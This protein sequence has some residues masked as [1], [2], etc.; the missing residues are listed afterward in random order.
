LSES[1]LDTLVEAVHQRHGFDV[2]A[3]DMSS[4]PLTMEA[5]LICTAANRIQARAISDHI[6]KTARSMGYRKHHLEGYDE[7]SWILLDFVDL[8]V[9]IFLPETR[10]YYNL[11]GLWSDLPRNVYDDGE[12]P[13]DDGP[14]DPQD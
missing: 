2:I 13:L 6:E 10:E 8:V 9:H 7:G 3:L 4:V 5:F 11:E 12:V 1:I 14:L